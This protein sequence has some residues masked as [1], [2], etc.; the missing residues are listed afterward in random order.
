MYTVK[1]LET[2]LKNFYYNFLNVFDFGM[3]FIVYE[4]L[5]SAFDLCVGNV[6][7]CLPNIVHLPAL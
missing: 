1:M 4:P 7:Y 2:M 3:P 6:V 5:S